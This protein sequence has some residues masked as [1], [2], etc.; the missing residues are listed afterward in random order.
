MLIAVALGCAAAGVISGLI[1][2]AALT[3]YGVWRLIC[4]LACG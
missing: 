2:G 4:R 1:L 3:L